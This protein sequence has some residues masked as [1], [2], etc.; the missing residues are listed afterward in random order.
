MRQPS[1][2]GESGCSALS[3]L[4]FVE[5]FLFVLCCSMTLGWVACVVARC[6]CGENSSLSCSG[7]LDVAKMYLAGKR[8]VVAA[9]A[10][11][12]FFAPCACR[13]MKSVGHSRTVL[14][15]NNEQVNTKRNHDLNFEQV[16]VATS[17]QDM[18]K[19]NL[20]VESM[21]HR[22]AEEVHGHIT[23][24]VSIRQGCTMARG[25]PMYRGGERRG[26]R[27]READVGSRS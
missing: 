2:G 12:F 26:M 14:L 16:M 8:A 3:Y 20:G 5:F 19:D 18:R 10:T 22:L 11:P 21:G 25:V 24:Q 15:S 4:P 1:R 23:R 27:F 9:P 17:L 6:W 13:K 7:C